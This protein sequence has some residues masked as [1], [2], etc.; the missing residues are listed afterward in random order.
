[1]CAR[2]APHPTKGHSI[3]GG[4]GHRAAADPDVVAAVLVRNQV[5]WGRADDPDVNLDD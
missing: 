5:E 4:Q 3:E 1:M 2:A